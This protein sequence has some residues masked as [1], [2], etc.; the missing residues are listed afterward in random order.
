M[1]GKCQ[2]GNQTIDDPYKM[3]W[4]CSN[5]PCHFTDP[6]SFDEATCHGTVISLT[7]MCDGHC[8]FNARKSMKRQNIHQ[9][10]TSEQ[11]DTSYLESIRSYAK[12]C[13]ESSTRCVPER[14]LCNGKVMC[15]NRN[16]LKWCKDSQRKTEDCGYS[17]Y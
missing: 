8:N 2:C 9:R 3:T 1:F 7:E 15:D 12:A 13:G 5:M 16:D 14:D 17:K 10:D 4:C 6:S 11:L